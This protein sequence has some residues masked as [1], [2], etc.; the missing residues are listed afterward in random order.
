[1]T[2]KQIA[3]GQVRSLRAIRKKL[4]QMSVQWSDVDEYNVRLLDDLADRVEDVAVSL[5]DEPDGAIVTGSARTRA[6]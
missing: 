3:A 5:L 1:M 4:Q 2:N 6:K